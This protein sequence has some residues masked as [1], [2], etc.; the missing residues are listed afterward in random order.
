MFLINLELT[1]LA[2]AGIFTLPSSLGSWLHRTFWEK[3]AR[4][5]GIRYHKLYSEDQAKL[6]VCF[7]QASRQFVTLKESKVVMEKKKDSVFVRLKLRV[8]VLK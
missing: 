6:A 1:V 8:P 7:L 2:T 4:K 3:D 5:S